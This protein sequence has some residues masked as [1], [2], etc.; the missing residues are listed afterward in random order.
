MC[1]MQ[2]IKKDAEENKPKIVEVGGF[3]VAPLL[4]N[5]KG[6]D[7]EYVFSKKTETPSLISTIPVKEVTFVNTALNPG[8]GN[9]APIEKTAQQLRE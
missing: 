5:D 9:F 8:N 2:K 1:P 4:N 7:Q 6:R 3:K